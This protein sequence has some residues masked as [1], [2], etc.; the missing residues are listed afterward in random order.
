M[1]ASKKKTD[2]VLGVKEKNKTDG[3][4]RSLTLF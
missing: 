4:L 1:E 2:W 3:V